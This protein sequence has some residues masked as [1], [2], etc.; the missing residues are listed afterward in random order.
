MKT[1]NRCL[2]RRRR[3]KLKNENSPA[4]RDSRNSILVSH[5]CNLRNLRTNFLPAQRYSGISILKVESENSTAQLDSKMSNGR[6]SGVFCRRQGGRLPE[7]SPAQRDSEMY[8]LKA[9]TENTLP[10][11]DSKMSNLVLTPSPQRSLRLN[12]LSAQQYS[13]MSNGRLSGV[14]CR[15]HGERLPET[16]PA[17]RDSGMYNLKAETENTLPQ[18]DSKMSN[19]VLTPSPQHPLRLNLFPAHRDSKMSNGRLSGGLCWPHGQKGIFTMQIENKTFFLTCEWDYEKQNGP[20]Q[21]DSKMSNMKTKT[22]NSLP[23]RHSKMSNGQLSGVSCWPHG[24]KGM[25]TARIKNKMDA[26]GVM[27]QKHKTKNSSAQ[28]DSEISNLTVSPTRPTSPTERQ[29]AP[30][31][32]DSGIYKLA[33]T[34]KTSPAQRDSIIYNLKDFLKT[35]PVKVNYIQWSK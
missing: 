6:L 21:R 4:Q 27:G 10:Q 19:L 8:N 17:Q 32:S 29:R 34:V 14:F 13:K 23:Q 24:Q 22:E 26:M 18:P 9:E 3:E 12:L 20:A 7:T 31:Q 1:K 11:P 28:Q 2:T 30:A 25:S 16:S 33:V 35:S 5:L 15:W